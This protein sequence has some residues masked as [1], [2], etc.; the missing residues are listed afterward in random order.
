MGRYRGPRQDSEGRVN[1]RRG[2]VR[3]G[4]R[5]DAA[6][7]G[8]RTLK[9]NSES[10]VVQVELS[11]SIKGSKKETQTSYHSQR[12]ITLPFPLPSPAGERRTP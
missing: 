10:D 6:R 5:T 7:A 3:R 12:K 11:I 1:C 9:G 4:D 8:P 2:G